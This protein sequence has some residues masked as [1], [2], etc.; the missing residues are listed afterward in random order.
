M[1]RPASSGSRRTAAPRS[2]RSAPFAGRLG[3]ALDRVLFYGKGGTAFANDKY[4]LNSIAAYRANE[5]RWGWMA[6]AGIEYSFTDNWSAKIEYNY[7]DFG[8]RAVRF[9]DTTGFFALDTS[10]RERIHVAKVG[11]QLSLRVGAGRRH[12]LSDPIT[13]TPPAARPSRA[14]A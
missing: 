3:F 2:T 5:T 9:T 14:R 12:L 11:H 1:R 13:L 6:G 10:I 8:S 7:L 4:E